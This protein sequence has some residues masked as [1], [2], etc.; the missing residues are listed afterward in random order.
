MVLVLIVGLTIHVHAVKDGRGQIVMT[1]LYNTALNVLVYLLCVRNVIT[2]MLSLRQVRSILNI[3]I[4][5]LSHD[6]G[7]SCELEDL[8]PLRP[9]QNGGT[10]SGR[11]GSYECSCPDTW[12]GV[13]CT[14][15]SDGYGIRNK[16]CGMNVHVCNACACVYIYVCICV[17]L[18]ACTYVYMCTCVCDCVCKCMCV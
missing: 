2:T 13:N 1:V 16:Q 10:C 15:C 7:K 14:E 11:P 5:W 8:C 18:C 9:C 3:Q 12:T 17:C 6:I 4:T